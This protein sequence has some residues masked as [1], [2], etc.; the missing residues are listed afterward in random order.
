[1]APS[2][3]DIALFTL[4]QRPP[5]QPDGS[6]MPALIGWQPDAG[7][8]LPMPNIQIGI[9]PDRRDHAIVAATWLFR[10][11][12]VHHFVFSYRGVSGRGTS[13]TRLFDDP[14]SE[15]I[16]AAYGIDRNHNEA[17]WVSEEHMLDDG[18]HAYG[19]PYLLARPYPNALFIRAIHQGHHHMPV[20]VEAA[21]PAKIE[22]W[23]TSLGHL[24]VRPDS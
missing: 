16:V 7:D 24:V 22:D 9:G 6:L 18:S 5:H 11:L 21:G 2:I 14:A 8:D 23:L 1:M 19:E 10:L 12:G 13:E 15:P 20:G 17:W 4:V 3:V